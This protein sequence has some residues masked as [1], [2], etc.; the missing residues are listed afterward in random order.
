MP[1][2]PEAHHALYADEAGVPLEAQLEAALA[3]NVASGLAGAEATSLAGVAAALIVEATTA[4][5]PNGTLE[6]L[7]VDFQDTLI[8]VTDHETA[9]FKCL[10]LAVPSSE[11]FAEA[12]VNFVQLSDAWET[13]AELN[14]KPELIL[15][16]VLT[17]DEWKAVYQELQDSPTVNHEGGITNGG[18][19]VHYDVASNW[20]ALQAN[21]H[22]IAVNG[23]AW[24]VLVLPG[25]DKPPVVN[26]NHSGRTAD[27]DWVELAQQASKL[28]ITL[29]EFAK[30][31]HARNITI[32]AY[33]TLQANR[34][35]ANIPYGAVS[36]VVDTESSTWLHG[37]VKSDL[38]NPLPPLWAPFGRWGAE[39]GR[40]D[41][42]WRD[43][44]FRQDNLGVRLPR[45]GKG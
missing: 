7:S 6:D 2:T 32:P 17:V 22:T 25:T 14:L 20:E 40:V 29:S 31:E 1:L 34:L 9:L 26:V 5:T 8:H 37:E 42:Y 39:G 41:L 10:N 28:G 43:I 33:L 21:D 11:A 4:T 35:L 13:M 30:S 16:P 3:R 15:A 27:G 38:P 12:G 24:Q 44:A 36:P 18:L 23:K 19:W 45:W